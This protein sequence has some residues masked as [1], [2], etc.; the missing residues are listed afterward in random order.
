MP[1][2]TV[3]HSKEVCFSRLSMRGTH[4]AVHRV[5]VFA[6]HARMTSVCAAATIQGKIL[7]N[8]CQEFCIVR[9]CKTMPPQL[10]SK[11]REDER[12]R[13]YEE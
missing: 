2:V 7:S 6:V 13:N 5:S 10:P 1:T 11:E 4:A 9:G 3:W 12:A 8:T